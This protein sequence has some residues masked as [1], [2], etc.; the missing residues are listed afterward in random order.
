MAL[1]QNM[2]CEWTLWHGQGMVINAFLKTIPQKA[3]HTHHHHVVEQV[4]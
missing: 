4:K 1:E 2:K 3:R